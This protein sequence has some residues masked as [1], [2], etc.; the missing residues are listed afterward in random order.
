MSPPPANF[1]RRFATTT[2]VPR[3]YATRTPIRTTT[4][5]YGG[6][7]APAHYYGGFYDNS[8]LWA[9][10]M[11]Y[12]HTPFHPAFYTHP[13]VYSNGVMYPGGFNWLNFFL[14]LLVFCALVLLIR[15]WMMKRRVA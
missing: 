11:W 1:S 8:F 15:R 6:Y 9:R 12:Y 5:V 10:P 4:F 14:G 3:T 13:P 2:S 7:S